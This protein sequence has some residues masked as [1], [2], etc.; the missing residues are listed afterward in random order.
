L[1]SS[2]ATPAVERRSLMVEAAK[3]PS[4]PEDTASAP[5]T[6]ASPPAAAAAPTVSDARP[7]S[8]ALAARVNGPSRAT[9]AAPTANKRRRATRSE[10]IEAASPGDA[11]LEGIFT[12][13]VQL[14]RRASDE[15]NGARELDGLFPNDEQATLGANGAPLPD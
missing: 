7:D 3:P 13:P 9:R 1:P 12:P 5:A 6:A 2:A 15:A 8:R 10:F 11:E 4:A 14:D